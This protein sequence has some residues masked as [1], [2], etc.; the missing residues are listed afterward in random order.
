[1]PKQPSVAEIFEHVPNAINLV[2]FPSSEVL[3]GLQ[4]FLGREVLL[5]SQDRRNPYEKRLVEPSFPLKHIG[6]RQ[7]FFQRIGSGRRIQK[8]FFDRELPGSYGLYESY[9]GFLEL[10]NQTYEIITTARSQL[11]HFKHMPET[12][13]VLSRIDGFDSQLESMLRKLKS[14]DDIR[15][16]AIDTQKGVVAMLSE[17]PKAEIELKSE[18]DK[19]EWG[20]ELFDEVRVKMK[21]QAIRIAKSLGL[22]FR[23]GIMDYVKEEFRFRRGK[24]N[25]RSDFERLAFPVRLHAF[26][27]KFL[28]ECEDYPSRLCDE[29]E[30]FGDFHRMPDLFSPRF[31]RS[32]DIK[33]LFPPKLMRRYLLDYFV[34]IDFKATSS[35]KKFLIAGLHS[36]GKSFFLENIVL[37]SLLGQI[38]FD[39][40]AQ[41]VLLPKYERIYYYRNVENNT[42]E[43]KLETE[44]N[45]INEII[46][47]ADSRD[48]VV[49][50][51][52]LDATSADIAN[53]LGSEI[54][55]RLMK[56]K[57]TVFITSHRNTDYE[58]L[59][60]NGWI[61]MSPG[62]RIEGDRIKPA[63]TLSRG[64]PDEEVN[65]RYVRER[66]SE[67]FSN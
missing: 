5:G 21:K 59:S 58:R 50:D 48:L 11:R 6:Q 33:G 38:G 25:L 43:G 63:L 41:S 12:Q 16:F 39:I 30:D 23:K 3:N 64:P 62:Y 49:I 26:Y 20:S 17:M 65:K 51:E 32:Y 47:R 22:D 15:T 8:T 42:R 60:E 35:E 27:N 19:G 18:D 28:E 61:L 44:L 55:D 52:F 14:I 4:R 36:G 9:S 2:G 31:G 34:P 54:L 10:C 37:L 24:E 53:S 7:D 29:E 57:S 66:Y 46:R 40:P 45:A 56:L 1:M 67:I 13:R